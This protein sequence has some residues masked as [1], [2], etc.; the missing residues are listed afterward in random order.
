MENQ[1]L[2]L[3]EAV[4]APG[5]LTVEV[6]RV[7]LD[8][9]RAW[10]PEA[11]LTS[12][13]AAPLAHVAAGSDPLDGPLP[14]ILIGCG[15]VAAGLSVALR[16]KA[17]RAGRKLLT[18]QTQH[19]R[20]SPGLFDL[21]IPPAH[22][23]LS[24]KNVLPILGAPNRVTSALLTD[25]A[26]RWQGRFADLPRPLVA[27]LI[28]GPS[29]AYGFGET[30]AKALC[31]QLLALKSE[32]KCGLVIT[33]SR[34]T[35][36]AVGAFLRKTLA[37]EGIWFWDGDGSNPYFGML[38]LADHIVVTADS[39]NMVTEAAGTGKPIHV[40]HLPGGSTKFDR[41]H[42]AMET[43]GFTRPLG[44]QLQCWRYEPLNEAARIAPRI[45]KL[46]GLSAPS[47]AVSGD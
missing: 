22:D 7:R 40:F 1:A 21:V 42:N 19:P 18:V 45:R 25:E 34:R 30:E 8:P 26:A 46:A 33:A 16:R 44:G 5:D 32:T 43:R 38:A 24:G 14:D 35:G 37:G 20:V 13:F 15:R 12:P 6:K 31:D 9:S 4:A 3:A 36:K 27:V 17:K 29:H 23:R 28:G 11:M 39:T 41:F 10:M 47:L 2:G